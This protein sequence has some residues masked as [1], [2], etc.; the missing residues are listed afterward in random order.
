[1][2]TRAGFSGIILVAAL[3]ACGGS[4][5]AADRST[6]TRGPLSLCT[7]PSNAADGAGL[8]GLGGLRVRNVSCAVGLRIAGSQRCLGELH[9]LV[10]H[11]SCVVEG[12]RWACAYRIVAAETGRGQCDAARHRQVDW[13]AGGGE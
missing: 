1:M 6:T 13:R 8:G 10:N 3:L 4:A 9:N 11:H 7:V 5:H 12:I 2:I